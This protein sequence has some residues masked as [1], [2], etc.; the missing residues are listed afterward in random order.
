MLYVPCYPGSKHPIGNYWHQKAVTLEQRNE[1][2]ACN[3]QWNWGILLGSE[4]GVDDAECDSPEATEA[5]SRLFGSIRTPWWSAKKGDHHLFRHDPR[6]DALGA[7]VVLQGIEFR[8]GGGGKAAQSICPPSIVD[9][10]KRKWGVS[11]EDCE[12]ASFPESVIALLLAAPPPRKS[13]PA[14]E[15]PEARNA[16]IRR[17]Q[18]YF[19]RHGVALNGIRYNDSGLTYVDLA[20]CPFKHPDNEKGAPVI[21]V[22]PD[23]SFNFFCYHA[24][25]TEKKRRW[26]AI[27]A[28]Y[29]PLCPNITINNELDRA[30]AKSIAVLGDEQLYQ[31]G[32]FLVE[33]AHEP[34]KPKQSI[35]DNGR[36]Q[37]RPISSAGLTVKLAGCAQ[38][39]KWN[40]KSQKMVACLPSE[41]IVNGVLASPEYRGIP[42]ITGI[43]GCP[44]LR[45]DGTIAS[46]SGYDPATGLYHDITGI[47]PPVMEPARAIELLENVV[48]DFPCRSPTD[49][50]GWFAALITL[51]SRYAFRGAAPLFLFDANAPRVG[52][53]LLIDLLALI[54]EG[55]LAA[56]ANYPKAVEELRKLITSV[57]LSGVPYLV[58]DNIKDKLGGPAL[59]MALTTT[60]WQDRLL[61]GN[62]QV[63]L[64]LTLV[65]L[66][67]VNNAMLTGDMIGRTVQCRLETT[68]EHP[69]QRTGFK[70]P[71]LAGY[72]LEHR[73][74]LA[75]AALSIPAG[76]IR[77]GCPD[78]HL[79]AWGGFEGW[80]NLVR[81]SL[82]WAGLADPDTRT[83]LA[84]Q[85]DDDTAQLSQ[86]MDGWAELGAPMTV[87]NAIDAADRGCAPTLKALLGEL[88][89]DRSR[90]L[91]YLLRA[92]KGRVCGGRK[93]END[94][95]RRWQV[96]ATV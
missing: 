89:G 92:F 57:A 73:R 83:T 81:S 75:V 69:G 39:Q 53:G 70:H 58:L 37:L 60:R 77:A 23:G 63:D 34:P 55:R 67:T 38:F 94:T 42:V 50:S 44:I 43:V 35:I 17:L 1:L 10:V 85:A 25:C 59:E 47:Y 31:R 49:K 64:P 13:R 27:E 74:A 66:A 18:K 93:F 40:A 56:R 22:F 84:E 46:K 36:P 32:G 16:T 72:V 6:L 26:P 68:L 79:P 3:P 14:A 88:Q 90:G 52:K 86:L 20:H 62:R 87:G 11:P 82:V 76:Y 4:S 15:L 91:V 19:E 78:Q 9:G 2:A 41:A 29:G 12:P 96:V 95:K 30:V 80:S 61:G 33:V 24:E 54:I 65:W 8:L 71:N 48:C 28:L 51:F 7:M 45:P 5:F 21:I